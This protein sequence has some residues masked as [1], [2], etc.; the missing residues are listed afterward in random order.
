V[1]FRLDVIRATRRASLS[2]QASQLLP[3]S[4]A[5]EEHEKKKIGKRESATQAVMP[6]PTFIEEKERTA[7][8]KKNK[9]SRQ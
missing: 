2:A 7:Q 1:P 4:D 9:P 5:G 8:Q 6:L 3:A